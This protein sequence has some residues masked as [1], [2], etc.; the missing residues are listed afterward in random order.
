MVFIPWFGFPLPFLPLSCSA[1]MEMSLK[2]ADGSRDWSMRKTL[3]GPCKVLFGALP[4]GF[5][6]ESSVVVQISF[7]HIT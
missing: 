6:S 1:L 7:S 2:W 5:L 4:S 3:E